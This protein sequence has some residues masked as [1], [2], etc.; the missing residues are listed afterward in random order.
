MDP[1]FNVSIG[2]SGASGGV[3]RLLQFANGD[4]LVAG[5]FTTVNGRPINALARVR[6]DGSVDPSFNAQLPADAIVAAIALATDGQLYVGGLFSQIGG[7]ARQS[8]A[9]LT[10]GG[11][12]DLTFDAGNRPL[13]ITTY[14]TRDF[15]NLITAILPQ[16]K[17]LH[18]AGTQLTPSTFYDDEAIFATLGPDGQLLDNTSY[19]RSPASVY[20]ALVL[21]PNGKLMLGTDSSDAKSW[22]DGLT[23][24]DSS[25]RINL[26]RFKTYCSGVGLSNPGSIECI[27]AYADGRVLAGGVF[28]NVVIDGYYDP[29]KLYN[30]A[31]VARLDPSFKFDPT[32]DVGGMASDRGYP[33]VNAMAFAPDGSIVIAGEFSSVGGLAR[34]N[35]ARLRSSAEAPVLLQQPQAQGTVAGN[36]VRLSVKAWGTPPLRYAWSKDGAPVPGET[37]ADLGIAQATTADTGSYRATVSN[38]GGSV[39][40]E[41]ADLQIMPQSVDPFGITVQVERSLSPTVAPFVVGPGPDGSLVV[42]CDRR[43][44]RYRADGTVDSS[45]ATSPAT[46]YELRTIAAVT[47]GDGTFWVLASYQQSIDVPFRFTLMHVMTSGEVTFHDDALAAWAQAYDLQWQPP[48]RMLMAVQRTT[49]SKPEL[50][51]VTLEGLPDPSFA[52]DARFADGRP[53]SFIVAADGSIYRLV[54]QPLTHT[55]PVALEHFDSDGRFVDSVILP[56]TG[57]TNTLG[58]RLPDGR[59]VIRSPEAPGI[60]RFWPDG[61]RDETFTPPKFRSSGYATGITD[62]QM[63]A[64]GALW[65]QGG[66][67]QVDGTA[68]RG[69]V[70]LFPDGAWD[71]SFNPRPWHSDWNS[72]GGVLLKQPTGMVALGIILAGS[73]TLNTQT[74]AYYPAQRATPGSLANLSTRGLAAQGQETLIVGFVLRPEMETMRT[75]VRGVGPSLQRFGV[76]RVVNDP[77]LLLFRGSDLIATND[78][79]QDDGPGIAALS[80][81]LGAFA[82]DPGS[83]DAAMQPRLPAGAFTAHVQAGASAVALAELY[84]TWEGNNRLLNV[85][86]R[87]LVGNRDNVLIGGFV[88]TGGPKRIMIRAVGPALEQFGLTGV[89]GDPRLRVMQGD[90]LVAEN[91]D[92]DNGGNGSLIA[93]AGARLGAFALT[94]GSRDAAWLGNLPSGAYTAIV[95]GS[96]GGSGVALV[97]IYDADP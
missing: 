65:A 6:P 60:E 12:L 75:L 74:L 59:V 45:F 35:L 94:S 43:I 38:A 63:E 58:V 25:K 14:V 76:T 96:D 93:S 48:N 20:N 54:S 80:S 88:I 84:R 70:R 44:L 5:R 78:E 13:P 87:A 49:T 29:S 3:L 32:F 81:E 37:R 68:R 19:A 82:L 26:N 42:A 83:H 18:I 28:T 62:V 47:M 55:P 27:L 21:L 23:T 7:G 46:F 95:S 41:A 69:A 52:P 66:F 9:R 36:S 72:A 30:Q 39:T 17:R 50:T 24:S 34:R 64:D 57:S 31:G 90:R 67:D 10:P 15:A 22:G 73:P 53:Y 1:S 16:D 33:S 86:S 89:L 61:R 79:W 77:R 85:S 2:Y 11:S 51:A 97:E 91:D 56:V 4:I 40:S 71:P 92:W 8:L